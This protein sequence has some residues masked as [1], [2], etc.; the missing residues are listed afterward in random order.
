MSDDE[1][2]RKALPDEMGGVA[3]VLLAD[4]S[5]RP[6]HDFTGRLSFA[7]P[8]TA[9]QYDRTEHPLFEVGYGLTYSDS[10]GLPELS[11]VSGVDTTGLPAGVWFSRGTADDD[12]SLRLVGAD[13]EGIVV[14]ASRAGSPDGNLQLSAVDHQAQE[15][16]RRL[17][18]SGPSRIELASATPLDLARETNGDVLLILVVNIARAPADKDIALQA[19]CEELACQAHLP[20]GPWLAAQP[21]DRWLRLG[22]PLKCLRAAGAEMQRLTVPVSLTGVDGLEF[23]LTEI[24]LGTETDHRLD[25]STTE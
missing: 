18:W 20:V 2:F 1:R 22:I 6:R 5:G 19:N 10:G 14:E 25:C 17:T 16:A 13:G 12:M 15:D 9:V 8:R 7:W 3:D 24:S 11:E 21:T 4:A 23:S